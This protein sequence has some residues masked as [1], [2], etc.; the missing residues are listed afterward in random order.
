MPKPLTVTIQGI[1]Y[2]GSYKINDDGDWVEQWVYF[3]N[4]KDIQEFNA[5]PGYKENLVKKAEREKIGLLTS[6][7]KEVLHL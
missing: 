5:H 7:V 2:T 3:N 6:L 4:D 1:E